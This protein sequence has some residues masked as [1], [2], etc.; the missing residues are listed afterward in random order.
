MVLATWAGCT[1]PVA[2]TS[3]S[4]SACGRSPVGRRPSSRPATAPVSALDRAGPSS[5]PTLT[6][7]GRRD[8]IIPV[9]QATL[10]DDA[11]TIAAVAHDTCLLPATDHG[12]DINW[13]GFATQIARARVEQ[14]LRQHG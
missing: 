2:A 1:A 13:G 14:F 3:T 10:L 11:L 4:T 5:P 12:F 8:R 7:H 9:E 6:L